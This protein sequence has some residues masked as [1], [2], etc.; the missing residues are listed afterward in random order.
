MLN[1]AKELGFGYTMH[2]EAPPGR[3]KPKTGTL[4]S[5]PVVIFFAI[6]RLCSQPL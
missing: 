3:R 1:N 5:V 4:L 6:V 2:Q